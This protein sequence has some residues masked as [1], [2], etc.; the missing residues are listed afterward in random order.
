MDVRLSARSIGLIAQMVLVATSG[1]A[2]SRL[3]TS[4]LNS[5]GADASTSLLSFSKQAATF[6]ILD[7]DGQ[8]VPNAKIMIGPRENVP[9]PGNVVRAND[10]GALAAPSEWTDAQPVTIEATGFVRATYF[11]ATPNQATFVLRRA[12]NFGKVELKGQ[13]SG[14]GQLRTDGFLDLGLVIPAI[15]RREVA[16]LGVSH[17]IS[18]EIDRM[19]VLGQDLTIPSNIT[20]PD[21]T[22][23]YI[24][25]I[26]FNKPQYRS[27]VAEQGAYK[28]VALHGR[29]PFRQTVDDLRSG[30]SFFDIL[31]TIDF[32]QGSVNDVMLNQASTSLNLAVNGGTLGKTLSFTAPSYA[33]GNIVLAAA[34]SQDGSLYYPT[35]LKNVAA[36][37]SVQLAVPASQA[38]K[39]ILASLRAKNLPTTGAA[40]EFTSSAILP[41]N[42]S[43]AVEFLPAVQAPTLSNQVLNLDQPTAPASLTPV[44]TF[45]TLNKVEMVSNGD[46]KV[47]RKTPQWDVYVP[48]WTAQM[49]LPL[50]PSTEPGTP[51]RMRWEVAY[52]A[53]AN[54]VTVTEFGPKAVETVTHITRSALDL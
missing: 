23:N 12:V 36:G 45:A 5:G 25:P 53:V 44:L 22:E 17:L 47:E 51:E 29:V 31:N 14:F 10:K 32:R 33:Q 21:Q 40:S 46:I 41:A 16:N 24:F 39:L 28:F 52:G 11:S 9:F 1:F 54:G 27:Y 8:P 34:I 7:Q 18:P 43:Q 48:A 13:T 42:A 26:R 3:G 19:T 37:S 38:P 20:F 35:D 2:C 50:F 49:E 15:S 4:D 6:S 30:K